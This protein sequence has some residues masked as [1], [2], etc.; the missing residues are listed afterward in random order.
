MNLECSCAYCG[1]VN[2]LL[3]CARCRSAYYCCKEHQ[4]QDWKKHKLHCVDI[5]HSSLGN[6][7]TQSPAKFSL[8]LSPNEPVSVDSEVK[9]HKRSSRHKKKS[10]VNNIGRN[11]SP[12]TH[13]GSSES[14]IISAR[15]EDLDPILELLQ[16]ATSTPTSSNN[17][18]G[19]S[20]MSSF[21]DVSLD[22]LLSLDENHPQDFKDFSKISLDNCEGFPPFH[23]R[24]EMVEQDIIDEVCRNVIRDMDDYG[25]CVVDNFLGPEEGMEVLKEVT[26]MYHTGV[27]QDGQLVSNKVKKD[28]KTIRGDQ[29]TW[30][31]GKET[32]CQ[33]I[34]KL[35]S[36]VDAIIMRANRMPAN[37][38]IGN[39]TI[40]GRTKVSYFKL[41]VSRVKGPTCHLQLFTV[42]CFLSRGV[43]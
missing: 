14:E 33:K 43:S 27:F 32:S 16:S 18:S 10:S 15:T 37:G 31:D 20:N 40:S 38:K 35:I 23:H 39:Y 3:R 41:F 11:V 21:N 9:K 36:K 17:E 2:N 26:G 24:N 22:Y 19:I 13:E 5:S 6:D 30:I 4:T 8:P 12:I 42:A 7:Y 1:K 34:G 29:I 25:V 28:L